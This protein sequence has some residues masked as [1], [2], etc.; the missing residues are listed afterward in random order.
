MATIRTVK[1]DDNNS[2]LRYNRTKQ[3]DFAPGTL[4]IERT[5]LDSSG[6][7]NGSLFLTLARYAKLHAI[8]RN[9]NLIGSNA[10]PATG[11]APTLVTAGLRILSDTFPSNPAD[12][13]S[14]SDKLDSI[15]PAQSDTDIVA[16][17]YASAFPAT[18]PAT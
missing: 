2:H 11:N 8:G 14:R 9:P 6:T 10:K 7:R 15:K 1:P 5:A 3:S 4:Y 17:F 12:R 18:K 16:K 13:Q